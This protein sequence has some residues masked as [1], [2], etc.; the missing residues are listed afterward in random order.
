MNINIPSIQTLYT[1]TE[2]GEVKQ[3]IGALLEDDD[4]YHTVEHIIAHTA[5]FECD[6]DIPWENHHVQKI[7]NNNYE[8]QI[9]DEIKFPIPEPNR[10]IKARI[11]NVLAFN[12]R[13]FKLGDE[14]EVD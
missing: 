1:F 5:E 13:Y 7:D 14:V 11:D 10:I 8:I 6:F 9:W 12:N 2:D 4:D 3:F